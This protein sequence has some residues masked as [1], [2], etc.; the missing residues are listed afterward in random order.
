[1]FQRKSLDFQQNYVPSP[2]EAALLPEPFRMLKVMDPGQG[3]PDSTWEHQAKTPGLERKG[4]SLSAHVEAEPMENQCG[5]VSRTW[6]RGP[7]SPLPTLGPALALEQAPPQLWP[8]TA[9]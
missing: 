4:L 3:D 5:A 6:E 7:H 2:R 8:I 1:M 9:H